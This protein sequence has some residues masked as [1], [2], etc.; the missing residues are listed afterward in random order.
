M[1]AAAW[2]CPHECDVD[3]PCDRSTGR[4]RDYL[5]RSSPAYAQMLVARLVDRSDQLVGQPFIGAEV[6]EW[7]DSNV[8][9][10]YVH[11]YRLIYRADGREVLVLAVI[12]TSRRMPMLPPATD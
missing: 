9:E 12:H 6:P 5:T 1:S 8:R 4:V 2:G 3:D 10:V 11:P 7:G